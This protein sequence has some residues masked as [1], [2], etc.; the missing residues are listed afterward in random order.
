MMTGVLLSIVGC[1]VPEQLHHVWLQGSA[2]RGEG[3]RGIEVVFAM[4]EQIIEEIKDMEPPT[5]H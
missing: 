2:D 3:G 5:L 4:M 1:G